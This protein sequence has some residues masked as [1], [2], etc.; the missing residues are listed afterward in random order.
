LDPDLHPSLPDHLPLPTVL[1]AFQTGVLAA[2]A[3]GSGFGYPVHSVEVRLQFLPGQHL[4]P[5]SSP[6]A[7]SSAARQAV[8]AAM[9]DA[10]HG[11]RGAEGEGRGGGAV[12]MEPL[13][14]VTIAV[15]EA[16]L[17]AVVHDLSSARGGAVV[18]LGSSSAAPHEDDG[19]SFTGAAV[20][21]EESGGSQHI[22]SIDVAR[23]YAP[24]DPFAGG[25]HEISSSASSSGVGEDAGTRQI[26][27]R[28]PL[29]EMVGY[30]KHLRSL[31]AGRGTF[32]MV[33]DRFE[34]MS[35]QRQR[36]VLGEMRGEYF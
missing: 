31:T 13:M 18:A 21:Q 24:P 8:Q 4:F 33:V 32:T 28:V 22:P 16:S 20:D 3:R 34:R 9:R 36:A 30:L 14:L 12:M 6:A 7:F 1:H 35:G 23:I 25:G 26:L 27:A 11:T 29:K 10:V 5:N 15:D 19:E 17:G 2:F